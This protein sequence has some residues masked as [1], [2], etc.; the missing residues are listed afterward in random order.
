MDI[1]KNL[2]APYDIAVTLQE[3]GFT[4]PCVAGYNRERALRISNFSNPQD[5]SKDFTESY[6]IGRYPAP[7]WSQVVDW[8]LSKI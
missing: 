6:Y 2:F 8:I 3:L 4:E 1:L 7:L 5:R